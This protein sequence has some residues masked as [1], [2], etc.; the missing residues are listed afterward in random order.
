MLAVIRVRGSI[1]AGREF[2]DTMKMLKLTRVNH[3]VLFPEKKEIEGMIKKVQSFVTF[4][5]INEITFEK[6]LEKRGK[7]KGDRKLDKEFL[8]KTGFNS[9]KELSKALIE[10]RATLRKAGIKE[11]FRLR[12]PRKG[13]ERKGIKKT[14]ALGGALGNRREKINELILRMI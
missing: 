14:F 1:R 2:L 13:F 3:L 9:I 10:G 12:P 6:L 8:K 11:V 5:Q 4:G 7:L